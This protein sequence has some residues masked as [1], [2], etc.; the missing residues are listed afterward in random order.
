MFDQLRDP[1]RVRDIGLTARHV[2]QVLGV[3]HPDREPVLQHVV[4]RFPVDAGRFHP[5]QRHLLLGQ[6]VREHFEL[7]GHRGERA[8]LRTPR[9]TRSRTAHRGHHC[10][11]VHIQA[12]APLDQHIHP[13]T[14]SRRRQGPPGVGNLSIKKLRCALEAAGQGASGS[15]R[16]TFLRARSTKKHRRRDRTTAPILIRPRVPA[17]AGMI[18]FFR[19]SFSMRSS[20]NSRSASRKRTR[21]LT[22]SGGSSPAWS[23]RYWLTQFPSVPSLM[24]SSRATWA[25]GR[26]PSITSLTASSLNS[27]VNLRYFLATSYITFR[28]RSYWIRSENNGAPHGSPA[29]CGRNAV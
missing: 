23:R 17:P 7:P 26:E 5:D 29:G 13:D 16:H 4:D 25:V 10:I 22:S 1:H 28:A 8:C 20:R 6:P 18:T 15:P 11:A 27:G 19:N 21:S 9:A 2:P 14:P 12:G 3:D 24:P